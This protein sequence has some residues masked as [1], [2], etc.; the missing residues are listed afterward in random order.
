V[1]SRRWLVATVASLALA[2]LVVTLLGG[3]ARSAP[4]GPAT[5]APG[6]AVDAE[7]FRLWLDEASARY[8][9]NDRDAEPKQAF[10]VVEGRVELTSPESVSSTTL[11]DALTADLTS[12]Y[13]QFGSPSETP[14]ASVRVSADGSSLLGLG[15]GLGYDVQIVFVVDETAVPAELTVTA[16]EHTRRASA[17]DGNL[18][19]FDATAAAQVTLDVAPLPATRPEVEDF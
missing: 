6:A 18:G 1:R 19:W 9:V 11:T 2:I 13:D 10:V 4:E 7:P 17:L 12:S 5:V 16:L 14:E 15:P 8:V 3:W